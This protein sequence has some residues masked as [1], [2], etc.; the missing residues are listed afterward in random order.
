MSAGTGGQDKAANKRVN[1]N[2]GTDKADRFDSF[3]NKLLNITTD[4]FILKRRKQFLEAENVKKGNEP[5][6]YHQVVERLFNLG[7]R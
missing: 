3:V 1:K 4:K 2:A 5:V 6:T 7:K